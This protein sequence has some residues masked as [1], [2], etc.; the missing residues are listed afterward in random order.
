MNDIKFLNEWIECGK[1]ASDEFFRFMAYWIAFNFLYNE[2]PARFEKKRI[3]LFV[4]A[5]AEILKK[6]D[7]FSTDE[8][9]IFLSAPV[10]DMRNY[11]NPNKGKEQMLFEK[12]CNKDMKS[13]FLTL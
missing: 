3:G 1:N 12:V 11:T 9:K 5:H 6:F 10:L 7:A 2:Q 4:T 13:L 8:V